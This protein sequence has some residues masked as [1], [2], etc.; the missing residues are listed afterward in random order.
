MSAKSVV[1]HDEPGL[2]GTDPANMLR[3]DG[4]CPLG[5]LQESDENL[6]MS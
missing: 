3:M 1:V 4:L 5:K 2:E 6:P